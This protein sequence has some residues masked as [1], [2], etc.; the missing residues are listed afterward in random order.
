M[1]KRTHEPESF[2][3]AQQGPDW[4][5]FFY[6]SRSPVLRSQLLTALLAGTPLTAERLPTTALADAVLLCE[7][8]RRYHAAEVVDDFAGLC[9]RVEEKWAEPAWTT[10]VFDQL[11]LN[12]V[13]FVTRF[14]SD[15]ALEMPETG[16]IPEMVGWYLEHGVPE[17]FRREVTR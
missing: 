8:A 13:G 14:R 6:C 10:R 1:T 7:G 12:A 4:P 9:R 11:Y 16:W 3:P 5:R 17:Y 15:C 2:V